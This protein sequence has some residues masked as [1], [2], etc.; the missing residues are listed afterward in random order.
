MT[1]TCVVAASFRSS[2]SRTR[3]GIP[4][5]ASKV[6]RSRRIRRR[7][8]ITSLEAAGASEQRT[9]VETS[10]SG[11]DEATRKSCGWLQGA[12]RGLV[13]PQLG[14]TDRSRRTTRVRRVVPAATSGPAYHV[15]T[16]ASRLR[17][18]AARQLMGGNSLIPKCVRPN[19][20][21]RPVCS[22]R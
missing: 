19:S 16:L 5:S 22:I 3:G 2:P 7:D 4:L 8:L 17:S 15:S 13:V 10:E 11:S 9:S 12:V 6:R 14:I 21:A 20:N 1:R 18:A